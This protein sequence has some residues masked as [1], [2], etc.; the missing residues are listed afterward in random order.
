MF[1]NEG[2]VTVSSHANMRVYNNNTAVSF[3][4]S[5][6][7]VDTTFIEQA[8]LRRLCVIVRE[9]SSEPLHLLIYSTDEMKM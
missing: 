8:L 2:T 5:R 4:S 6:L 7:R 9:K 1:N 3:T